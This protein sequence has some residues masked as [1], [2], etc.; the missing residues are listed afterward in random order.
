[1]K[2]TIITKYFLD[3][4]SYGVVKYKKD[5]EISKTVKKPS[6][7]ISNYAERIILL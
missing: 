5:V 6:V 1:M 3:P 4:L 2:L 7:Y